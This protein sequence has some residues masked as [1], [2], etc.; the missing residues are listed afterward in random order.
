MVLYVVILYLFILFKVKIL[1]K[2]LFHPNKGIQSLSFLSL[3]FS[4][5]NAIHASI[6]I[7]KN[8][9]HAFEIV[10]VAVVFLDNKDL[11]KIIRKELISNKNMKSIKNDKGWKEYWNI[12]EEYLLKICKTTSI[13]LEEIFSIPN[14]QDD[15]AEKYCPICLTEYTSEAIICSDC[16]TKLEKYSR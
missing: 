2:K 3:I 6:Y 1:N 8:L 11:K 12:K 14:K 4:H 15:T 7:T 9:Y 16:E 13:T 10:T 5:I